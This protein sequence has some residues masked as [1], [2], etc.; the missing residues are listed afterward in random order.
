MS[1]VRGGTSGRAGRSHFIKA[2]AAESLGKWPGSPKLDWKVPGQ[3]NTGWGASVSESSS[4]APRMDVLGRE[5]SRCGTLSCLH[6]WGQ[7]T[8][9][10]HHSQATDPSPQSLGVGSPHTH[11]AGTE[12]SPDSGLRAEG[13]RALNLTCLSW[14]PRPAR[15]S[16]GAP[17]ALSPHI[18]SC[19]GLMSPSVSI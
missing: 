1:L 5:G 19:H 16:Q 2:G 14:K 10:S 13:V 6:P 11:P 8:N 18:S 17:T 4:W 7:I 9:L 12:F 3:Q 15:C